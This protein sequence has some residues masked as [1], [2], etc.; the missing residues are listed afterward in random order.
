MMIPT[1]ISVGSTRYTVRL[2][3]TLSGP[4]TR[5]LIKFP[6]VAT[7]HLA[8]RCNVSR[9]RLKDA[10]INT[11]FWHEITHAVLHSMD[12]PLCFDEK[13][14]TAFSTKLSHAIDSARF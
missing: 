9:K 3:D 14:V 12:H 6:P 1:T 11:T 13:F 8:Q 4:W 2:K 5:G 10:D 7:I